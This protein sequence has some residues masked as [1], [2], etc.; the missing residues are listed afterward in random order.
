MKKS[1]ILAFGLVIAFSAYVQA[2]YEAPPGIVTRSDKITNWQL[3]ELD[4]D[5]DG[6]LTLDE[7][8]KKTENYGREERRNVRRAQKEGFY[9]SPEEQFKAMDKDKDGKVSDEE[10][11]DFVR[12]QRD[13]HG[14]YY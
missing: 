8:K 13:K 14:M 6:K 9:M 1:V 2:K 7:F 10:M 4:E 5:G 11:A 3:N 12:E